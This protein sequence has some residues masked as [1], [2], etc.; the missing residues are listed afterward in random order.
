MTEFIET[1]HH[2]DIKPNLQSVLNVS[3]PD[4]TITIH[5]GVA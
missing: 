5:E 4:F 2:T 1:L 3:L